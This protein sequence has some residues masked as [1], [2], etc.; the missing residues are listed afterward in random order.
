M[1]MK[2]TIMYS[3]YVKTL[4][5][6]TWMSRRMHNNAGNS[7]HRS[8]GVGGGGYIVNIIVVLS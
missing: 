8:T 5:V 7:H 6:R 3:I 4:I 1:S 2:Y